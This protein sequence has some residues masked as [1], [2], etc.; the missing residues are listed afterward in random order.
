MAQGGSELL[1]RREGEVGSSGDESDDGAGTTEG[2]Q[3]DDDDSMDTG[4]DGGE[5]NGTDLGVGAGVDNGVRN[6]D[7]S[8]HSTDQCDN[9]CRKI[10]HR[11]N[12]LGLG[13]ATNHYTMS[14]DPIKSDDIKKIQTPLRRVKVH[15]PGNSQ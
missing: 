13:G 1:E 11:R 8:V 12:N 9:C 6:D 2:G 14:L 5:S 15:S 7:S 10:I 3:P 4:S